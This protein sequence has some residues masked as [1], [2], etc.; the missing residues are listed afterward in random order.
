MKFMNMRL[1]SKYL[2]WLDMPS[3]QVKLDHGNESL[4]R[5][6]DIR[7]AEHNFGVGHETMVLLVNMP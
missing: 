2:R 5:V 3:T 1:S 4:Y 7:H 6:V